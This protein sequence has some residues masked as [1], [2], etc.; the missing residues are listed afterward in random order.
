MIQ[1]KQTLFILAAL[2]LTVVCM[3]LQIGTYLADGLPV[4][5]MYNLWITS[6][7]NGSYDFSTWPLFAILLLTTPVGIY[8]VMAY[9]NRLL[10]A[11][12]CVFNMLMLVGWYICYAAM[13]QVWGSG[14]EFKVSFTAALPALG[15]IFYFMARAAILADE[16]MVRAA[17]RIR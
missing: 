3:C 15:I 6:T 9:T 12:L 10:Q 5:K 4:G 17:D 14:L 8:A 16:R 7:A 11:R 13:G 2:I 1:R